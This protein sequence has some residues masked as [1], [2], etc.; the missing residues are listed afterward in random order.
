VRQ[1]FLGRRKKTREEK[2]T[3]VASLHSS[4]NT[5]LPSTPPPPLINV[6]MLH[7]SHTSHTPLHTPHS[8][9]HTPHFSISS[10]FTLHTSHFTLHT[11][12][13]TL[14]TSHFSYLFLFYLHIGQMKDLL[15]FMRGKCSFADCSC[16]DYSF[17]GQSNNCTVCV[18][19][20]SVHTKGI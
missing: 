10:H 3:S 8:T 17:D 7:T 5:P 16:P 9:L 19:K 4:M 6:S 18:H 14:H 12:H 20:P 13:F 11:S 15:G 1:L 2:N